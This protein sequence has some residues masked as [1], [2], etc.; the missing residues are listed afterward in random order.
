MHAAKVRSHTGHIPRST[1][2]TLLG[3]QHRAVD[4]HPSDTPAHLMRPGTFRH[5]HML[6]LA[7]RYAIVIR[8]TM[9]ALGALLL[10]CVAAL[11]VLAYAYEDEVKARLVAELN[12]HLNVPVHQSGIDLT[13]LRRF[14]N[15]SLRITDVYIQEVRSDSIAPDTLLYAQ[16]LDLEISLFAMLRGDYT[17]RQLHGEH[18]R[19]NCGLDERGNGTWSIW[20]ADSTAEGGTDIKL[21]KVYFDG[22]RARYHDDRSGLQVT[23]SSDHLGLRGRFRPE[24]SALEIE[25]DVHLAELRDHQGLVVHDREANVKLQLA[26]GGAAGVFSV[27]KG[28]E[29]TLKGTPIAVTLDLKGKDKARSLDLRASGFNLAL[30]ELEAMLPDDLRQRL[31]RYELNGEADVALHCHGPVDALAMSV[32]LSLREGRLTEHRSGVSFKRVRGQFAMELAPRTGLHKLVVEG[33]S[34]DC[35]SG[36]ITGSMELK[37]VTNATLKADVNADLAI[38]DLLHFAGVDTLEEARGRL[39]TTL[40]AAGKLR[41]VSRFKAA[42]L[43][44]LVIA[45]NAELQDASLKMRGVRHRLTD[46]N[47]VLTLQGNDASVRDLRCVV[48]GNSIALNGTLH[49]LIPYLLFPDQHLAVDAR[50]TSPELDLGALLATDDPNATAQKRTSYTLRLPDQVDLDLQATVGKL[51]LEG[52]SATDIAG[53]VLI[54][55]QVLRVPAITF[56]S[57]GGDVHGALTLDTHGTSAFPLGITASVKNMDIAVLFTEF[58]NFGQRFITD[59]HLKGRSD[60]QLTLSAALSPTLQ[61]DQQSLH[62]VAN[63]VIQGGELNEHPPMVAIADYVRGNKLIAPFVDN[64]ELR[65]RLAHVRFASLENQVEIKDRMV[66]VPTMTVKSSAMDI[67]VSAAQGFDG[68]VDD[69]VNF[70]LGDLFRKQAPADEFG[71]IVDD[72]TGLRVFLHMFGTTSALQFKNDGAAASA[73]R[74]ERMKQETAQLKGILRD[75]W[76]GKDATTAPEQQGTII[77]LDQGRSDSLRSASEANARDRRKGLG[78]LLGKGGKDDDQQETITIE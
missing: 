32:G 7:R 16:H 53:S 70:R 40:H 9:L 51:V 12:A 36:H 39:K 64:D 42:D 38:A 69:H 19:L 67:E 75:I 1:G 22:L 74:Q 3:K 77:T 57:A 59:Q 72:G 52:F 33:L 56:R 24:G 4:D 11:F 18:V 44:G 30:G 20:K 26:F 43:R 60:V 37:G 62:C 55:D 8:R 31:R 35:P 29:V 13:L 68:A 78:R 25:G 10:L 63:V 41:D 28:S 21:R 49:N 17:V 2:G 5:L 71:P 50:G 73:R 61:L 47:G 58:R 45:G 46:L 6:R 54:K 66:Y 65:Q 27:T 34:A 15:A 48:Q 23:S 76:H 14:P